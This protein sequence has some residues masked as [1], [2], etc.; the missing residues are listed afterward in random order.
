MQACNP[1]CL[2]ARVDP[3][4]NCSYGL[5]AQSR[6]F[7]VG[8]C[9]SNPPSLA[10]VHSSNVASSSGRSLSAKEKLSLLDKAKERRLEA[11]SQDG[12]TPYRSG[13]PGIVDVRLYQSAVESQK[14]MSAKLAEAN[15]HVS[16]LERRI[17]EANKDL[18]DAAAFLKKVSMEFGTTS[19]LVESTAAAVRFGVDKED[20]V[21][22]LVKLCERLETLE[23]SLQ[24]QRTAFAKRVPKRVPVAWVG[25]ASEVRLM[26]D[27]DGWTRGFELSAA[28]IDSDG[29]IRTFEADLPL[30]PGRYKV[31]FQVDG[32]W[33][34]ASDWPTENDE[35]G[36][37]NS[38]LVVQ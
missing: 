11:L 3:K 9:R 35:L 7:Q 32:G 38:I 22:K 20:A 2:H 36:E 33:R 10:E 16:Y 6:P 31:K 14:R 19:R 30:L 28:S 15:A 13:A 18:Q 24:A 5:H 4:C 1:N 29:V 23:A 37:T 26:G 21:A 12:L 27:F 17:E 8:V 25:V 34:L